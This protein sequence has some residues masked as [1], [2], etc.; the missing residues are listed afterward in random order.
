MRGN[1]CKRTFLQDEEGT[2]LKGLKGLALDMSGYVLRVEKYVS[3]L[4]NCQHTLWWHI[5]FLPFT[6][7]I[8]NVHN[9]SAYEK[10]Y[11]FWLIFIEKCCLVYRWLKKEYHLKIW[12]LFNILTK[13]AS[14]FHGKITRYNKL[15]CFLDSIY[16]TFVHLIWKWGGKSLYK[17][18][19]GIIRT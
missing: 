16:H 18:Q 2:I 3:R 19:K 15:L 17:E 13:W 1:L 8:F 4:I 7:F 11:V 14:K 5:Y 9:F 12:K 6:I 10:N